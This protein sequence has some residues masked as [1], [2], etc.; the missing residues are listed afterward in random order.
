M[1]GSRINITSDDLS[2][3]EYT[4]CVIKESLRKWPPGAGFDRVSPPR[5]IELNGISIPKNTW[6]IV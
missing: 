5:D 4:S 1:V 2:K 6:L 3:L